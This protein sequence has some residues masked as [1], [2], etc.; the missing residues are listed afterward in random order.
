MGKSRKFGNWRD[1][2]VRVWGPAVEAIQLAWVED[3]HWATG[4]VP[5][6]RWEPV[7]APNSSDQTA[8]VLPTGP[9]DSLES[10]DLMFVKALQEA[11]ERCW[12]ASP[13]FIPDSQTMAAMQLAAIRGVD[14]RFLIPEK[15]D[16]WL[17][18]HAAWSFFGTAQKAGVRIFRY[19]PGFMHQKAFLIDDDFA[20]VGTANFDNRSFRLNFEMTLLVADRQFASEVETMF[21]SDFALSKELPKFD[22]EAQPAWFQFKARYANM[23]AQIL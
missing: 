12:I 4:E 22:L 18:W 10:C 3:W 6:L 7:P 21:E 2:Q 23:F 13:Y 16:H 17:V 9:A 14:V 20:A 1:T 8:L 15:K 5:E 19:Q 11:R